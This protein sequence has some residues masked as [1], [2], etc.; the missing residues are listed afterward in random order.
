MQKFSLTPKPGTCHQITHYY[1]FALPPSITSSL[2]I[3]MYILIEIENYNVLPS[4]QTLSLADLYQQCIQFR[5]LWPQNVEYVPLVHSS[6]QHIVNAQEIL[7]NKRCTLLLRLK[8]LIRQMGEL[9]KSA[10]SQL[11]GII[12]TWIKKSYEL[13][14]IVSSIFHNFQIG[15]LRNPCSL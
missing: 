12:T 10:V 11:V 3:H 1:L 13:V 5:Q 4:S 6:A 7:K 8:V 14:T 15:S 2:S 9:P